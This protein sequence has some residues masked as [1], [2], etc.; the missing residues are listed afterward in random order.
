MEKGKS[1][2][3]FYKTVIEPQLPELRQQD[4]RT[5]YW[6]WIMLV[7]VF[8]LAGS[9]L[10]F[11]MPLLSFANWPLSI[12]LAIITGYALYKYTKNNDAFTDYFKDH[13]IAEVI[14]YLDP[15]FIYKPASMVSSAEYLT[16]ALYRRRYDYFDGDD[17]FAGEY[18]GVHFHCSELHTYI[19]STRNSSSKRY[20]TVFKGLFF[21]ANVSKAFK[22]GTYFWEKDEEELA[23]SIAD[24]HLRLT[25]LPDV[26]QMRTGDALFDQTY[27]MYTT[28]PDDARKIV[29]SGFTSLLLQLKKQLNRRLHVS[30]VAGKCYVAVPINEDLFEPEIP[31]A[32][33]DEVK[34]YFYTA[35]LALNIIAQ[36]QLDSLQ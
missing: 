11:F 18:K 26:S 5:N 3:T 6:G 31:P 17:F 20:N 7:S 28:M 24:E 35:M 27:S 10:S 22:G 23:T 9:L 34:K 32:E 29:Q 2:D 4:K 1:F 14:K 33:R 8:A 15:H 25:P 16:S 13:V 12:A 19:A 21:V 36:L 30:I